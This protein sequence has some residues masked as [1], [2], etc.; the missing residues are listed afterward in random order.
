MPASHEVADKIPAV[1][2]SS[3]RLKVQSSET[4]TDEREWPGQVFENLELSYE[5]AM[6][7]YVAASRAKEQRPKKEQDDA[8]QQA[9]SGSLKAQKRM[10]RRQEVQLRDERRQVREKRKLEDAAWRDAR[11]A[12]KIEQ[13]NDQALSKEKLRQQRQARQARDEPGAAYVNNAGIP[14]NSAN[15]R[16]RPGGKSVTVSENISL[17]CPSLLPGLPFWSSS[18]TVLDSV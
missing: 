1:S 14:L 3:G 10:L 12:R 4:E 16:T 13:Q 5:E 2:G 11:I 15:W 6:L 8:K 9:G 17:N 7:E 18:I